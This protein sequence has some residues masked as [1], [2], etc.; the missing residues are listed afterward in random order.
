MC[1]DIGR[2]LLVWYQ[3]IGLVVEPLP[4]ARET[5][6]Q[7][8]VES[9][10]RLKKQY[11]IPPCLTLSIIRYISTVKWSNPG[12][13]VMPSVTPRCSSYLKGSFQVAID[14]NCQLNFFIISIVFICIY[15][16]VLVGRVFA[17]GPGNRVSIPGE[18]IPKTQ[19]VVLDTSLL[20]TQYYK[21]RVKG[22]VEQSRERSS[23]LPNTSV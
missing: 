19:K 12:K 10:Q 11:L 15:L 16:V 9:Y 5:G 21:V 17:N 8:Q 4:M 13:G 7:S 1:I 14:Y 3:S 22:K 20:N 18:V 6:V 2:L 23:A